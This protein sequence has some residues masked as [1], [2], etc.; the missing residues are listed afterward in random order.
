M[1]VTGFL[2]EQ[3]QIEKRRLAHEK[4]ARRMEEVRALAK[5]IQCNCDLDRWEPE[6]DTGHS[7]VCRIHK[8]YK[9]GKRA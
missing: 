5:T 8:A 4:H 9:A 3:E 7:H 6:R 2:N 1:N